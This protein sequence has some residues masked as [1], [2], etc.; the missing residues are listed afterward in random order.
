MGGLRLSGTWSAS[1]PADGPDGARFIRGEINNAD[2]GPFRSWTRTLSSV[3]H[4][5]VCMQALPLPAI[6]SRLSSPA[7]AD[8]STAVLRHST[9]ARIC[10]EA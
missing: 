2:K 9:V 6:S 7:V 10:T 1:N 5:I 4:R 8:F 3:Q